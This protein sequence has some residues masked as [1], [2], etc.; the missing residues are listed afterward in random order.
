MAFPATI[1]VLQRGLLLPLRICAH[2]K[3]IGTLGG[4]LCVGIASI[5]AAETAR[6]V[7]T[8]RLAFGRDGSEMPTPKEGSTKD[9]DWS[10][11]IKNAPVNDEGG[12]TKSSLRYA[13]G[14]GQESA[15][16]EA[17]TEGAE[18]TDDLRIQNKLH[19]HKWEAPISSSSH[20]QTFPNMHH[21]A[22]TAID[23]EDGNNN[24]VPPSSSH[25][26]HVTIQRSSAPHSSIS[27]APT[28]APTPSQS[29]IAMTS[30]H[31]PLEYAVM[32]LASSPYLKERWLLYA[33]V[34]IT[35]FTGL[36]GRL[37]AVAPSNIRYPGAYADA[38]LPAAG[39]SYATAK[40]KLALK[41]IFH[42]SGCHTCGR[43]W[44]YVVGDH[45]PP[46][47][48]VKPGEQQR[49]FPQ[50]SRCSHMQGSVLSVRG[51]LL[52]PHLSLRFFH[53]W[54]PLGLLLAIYIGID[55]AII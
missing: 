3:I 21:Q 52:Q 38:F 34:G 1:V 5:V 33:I 50:C 27:A 23:V 44:G 8:S 12:N 26:H 13:P 10:L 20:F 30:N 18:D 46:N 45:M 51:E 32:S 29:H 28:P 49:F 54:I 2:Q 22:H 16:D 7:F 43:R 35:V 53:V 17:N 39:P 9:S 40:E 4:G 37:R 31:T 11:V 48:Y 41:E 36:G 55:P 6:G 47:L 19:L 42:K 25:D 14:I 15:D 24:P